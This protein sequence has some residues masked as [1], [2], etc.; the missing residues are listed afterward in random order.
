MTADERYYLAAAC[1]ALKAG[2]MR[3]AL[4]VVPMALRRQVRTA[5]TAPP[6]P[7]PKPKKAARSLPA[8]TP[9]GTDV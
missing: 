3:E 4:A 9:V 5:L 6:A 8:T 7:K 1:A 2:T